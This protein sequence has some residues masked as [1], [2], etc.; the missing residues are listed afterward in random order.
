[1]KYQMTLHTYYH[2]Y[3]NVRKDLTSLQA[4]RMPPGWPEVGVRMLDSS[5]SL[6][7]KQELSRILALSFGPNN[8]P[9]M[10]L[11]IPPMMPNG[12]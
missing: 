11:R 2:Y 9:I 5:R 10:P 6:R 1:M 4:Y 3:E 8:A 7:S 12:P